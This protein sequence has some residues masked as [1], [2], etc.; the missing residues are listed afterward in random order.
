MKKLTDI[1][2]FD[3]D[4]QSKSIYFGTAKLKLEIGQRDVTLVPET[5]VTAVFCRTNINN[6]RC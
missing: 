2:E 6:S 4:S 3:T 5:P 1:L